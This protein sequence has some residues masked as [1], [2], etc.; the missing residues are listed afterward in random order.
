MVII[1]EYRTKHHNLFTYLFIKEFNLLVQEINKIIRNKK[2]QIDKIKEIDNI[3]L[4]LEPQDK[5]FLRICY[6]QTKSR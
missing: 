1:E 4:N 3:N 6:G 2:F 5:D